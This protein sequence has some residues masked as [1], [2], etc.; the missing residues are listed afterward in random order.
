M[1]ETLLPP[2]SSSGQTS[3]GNSGN[4][5]SSSGNQ[6]SQTP[7][8]THAQTG[9]NTA[10]ETAAQ[11]DD[12]TYSAAP[13]Q[14]DGDTEADAGAAAGEPP[15]AVDDNDI[16]EDGDSAGSAP[17]PTDASQPSEQVNAAPSSTVE[18]DSAQNDSKA[19]SATTAPAAAG[20]NPQQQAA[21]VQS[22]PT[23]VSSVSAPTSHTL[24]LKNDAALER[25]F[26]AVNDA[27]FTALRNRA[28]AAQKD[29]IIRGVL[30]AIEKSTFE[31]TALKASQ[32]TDT[33]NETNLIVRY[34]A[35]A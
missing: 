11:D 9:E 25:S 2:T 15:S 16:S 33:E 22:R 1:L 24:V 27:A 8:G 34:Y 12:G 7:P 4:T 3:L 28:I 17:E 18:T 26:R 14:P 20:P 31:G 5:N 6:A 21:P 30:D 29:Q 10:L 13:T 35:E 19:D 23:A 32:D